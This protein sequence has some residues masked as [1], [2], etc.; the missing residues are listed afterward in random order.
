MSLE[1]EVGKYRFEAAG[2]DIEVKMQ[3]GKLVAIVPDQPVYTLEN[4]K[5][6][7]YK[8]TGAP[9]GFFMTFTDKDAYLEQPQG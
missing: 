1:K 6:R 5:D 2:F 4:V 7:K 8:L 3:D 9:D